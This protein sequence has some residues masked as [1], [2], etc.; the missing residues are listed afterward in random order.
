MH[1]DVTRARGARRGGG[2]LLAALLGCVDPP[3]PGDYVRRE[4]DGCGGEVTQCGDAATLWRCVERRW[5][6]VGCDEVCAERGG[7]RGCLV[8]EPS[9]DRCLCVDE[10]P[11][12]A[13]GQAQ[14][15][16]EAAIRVCDEATFQYRDATC[17]ALCAALDPPHRQLGCAELLEK[18]AA[19]TC[20]TEGTPCVP[21]APPH[22]ESFSVARCEAGVWA[23]EPCSC[24]L[25]AAACQ[26]FGPGG[27]ECACD[28]G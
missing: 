4:G 1:T 13:P 22:C 20:T 3:E 14:C 7:A 16:G 26:P 9:A 17:E 24:D 23:L 27:A 2:I 10:V 25:G 18:A 19:C 28:S 12:C 21:G 15:V 5:D 11:A 8:S 6:V